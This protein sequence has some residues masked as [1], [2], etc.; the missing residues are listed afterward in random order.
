MTHAW[1]TSMPNH[2]LKLVLVALCDNASDQGDCWPSLPH[3]ARKCDLSVEATRRQVNKLSAMGYVSISKETGKGNH[4]HLYPHTP[5]GGPITDPRTATGTTPVPRQGL[6][7][8][9]DR[10]SITENQQQTLNMQIDTKVKNRGTVIE[11][12]IEPSKGQRA[13]LV[14]LLKEFPNALKTAR[15]MNKWQVWMNHR[16]AFQKP[17]DWAVMFNEQ[18]E[19]LSKFDEPTVFEILSTSTRNG[20]R[21][22][23]PLNGG[24]APPVQLS[25]L[26]Q[27]LN[28]F[29]RE[30]DGI[31]REYP[32]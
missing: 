9:A 15:V 17:K 14:V 25:I 8:V 4:Y 11:P 26:D 16:R 1:D 24:K 27:D 13:G 5:T 22:L 10:V 7:P 28:K 20:W 2:T 21:G 30:A 12:S 31:I 29:L 23:F 19:W 6:P 3:L 32:V 18:I